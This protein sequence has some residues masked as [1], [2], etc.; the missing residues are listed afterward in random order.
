M[1]NNKQ[2]YYINIIS[3]ANLPIKYLININD[4]TETYNSLKEAED[5]FE[6]ISGVKL[7]WKNLLS[8]E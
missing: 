1:K 3:E 2:K 4:K 5:R 7:Y 6:E 8:N